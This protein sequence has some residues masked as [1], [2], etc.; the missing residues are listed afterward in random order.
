MTTKITNACSVDAPCEECVPACSLCALAPATT[1]H[2]LAVCWSCKAWL[3]HLLIDERA[4]EALIND[5][6]KPAV[7]DFYD[8][9][10]NGRLA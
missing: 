6:L 7:L 9:A 8:D 5:Y 1:T 3:I 2:G 10:K 4:V